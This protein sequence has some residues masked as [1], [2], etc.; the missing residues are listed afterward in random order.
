MLNQTY[1]NK[2][3][4]LEVFAINREIDDDKKFNNDKGYNKIF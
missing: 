1:Q 3:N 2:L 4:S